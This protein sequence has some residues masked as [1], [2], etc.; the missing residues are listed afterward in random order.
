MMDKR[1]KNCA[2][3]VPMHI[4]EVIDT[5]KKIKKEQGDIPVAGYGGVRGI[6]IEVMECDKP[7]S[8][9]G[10]AFTH[11]RRRIKLRTGVRQLIPKK[12]PTTKY[13]WIWS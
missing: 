4:G 7:L 10:S 6:Y 13:I 12:N 9:L 2:Q 1:I 3:C 5:L 11:T 8:D